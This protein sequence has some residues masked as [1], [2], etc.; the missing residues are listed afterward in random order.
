MGQWVTYAEAERLLGKER[1]S[2][3][4]AVR[5][6]RLPVRRPA[7]LGAGQLALVDVSAIDSWEMRPAGWLTSA[8]AAEALGV[9]RDTVARWCAK[10]LLRAVKVG[11]QWFIAPDAA[12]RGP[13][14]SPDVEPGVTVVQ[15]ATMLNLPVMTLR[16]AVAAGEVPSAPERHGRR[17]QLVEFEAWM[18]SKRAKQ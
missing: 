14:G 1:S 5:E 9:G 4:R 12:R 11:Y 13:L 3:N 17:V 6:G 7:R 18:E 10:G 16:R 8:E 15:A 2:L